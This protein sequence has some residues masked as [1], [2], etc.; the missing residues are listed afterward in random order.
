MAALGCQ[1]RARAHY[2]SK[3]AASAERATTAAT[4]GEKKYKRIEA[5]RGTDADPIRGEIYKK[6]EEK[7]GETREMWMKVVSLRP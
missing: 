7:C 4:A 6:N 3:R 5:E 1:K 2:M